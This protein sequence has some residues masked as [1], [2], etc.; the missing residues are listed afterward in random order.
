M[1]PRFFAAIFYTVIV[2]TTLSIVPAAL[3]YGDAS[4]FFGNIVDF[5]DLDT[6]QVVPTAAGLVALNLNVLYLPIVVGI[7]ISAAVETQDATV[8]Y[9]RR[10]FYR[11]VVFSVII[12]GVFYAHLTAVIVCNV[13]TV[14]T[15]FGQSTVAFSLGF[16]VDELIHKLRR[17]ADKLEID[18]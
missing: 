18:R 14:S 9:R 2:V 13:G 6:R 16:T 15:I 3:L 12:A 10:A 17:I 7:I 4:S 5:L 8:F 11:R 1:S